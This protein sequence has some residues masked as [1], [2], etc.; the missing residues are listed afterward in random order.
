MAL[1]A[2]R[3]DFK[4]HRTDAK[5]KDANQPGRLFEVWFRGVSPA[6]LRR[7]KSTKNASH[8]GHEEHKVKDHKDGRRSACG[9]GRQ[10][11]RGRHRK[12][13]APGIERGL[14]R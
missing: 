6:R 2:R 1:D 10:R 5:V 8:K 13:A 11:A 3:I 4:L 14:F 9:A 12:Q 7:H